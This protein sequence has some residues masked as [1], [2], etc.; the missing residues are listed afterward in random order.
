MFLN[1]HRSRR[2]LIYLH[3]QA[4]TCHNI[5][6]K[7]SGISLTGRLAAYAQVTLWAPSRLTH[8]LPQAMLAAKYLWKLCKFMRSHAWKF[9]PPCLEEDSGELMVLLH[10]EGRQQ[11]VCGNVD[12][13]TLHF[14]IVTLQCRARDLTVIMHFS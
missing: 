1:G 2:P 4:D 9:I 8:A 12:S 7:L 3:C 14:N 5:S 10:V 13:I 6:G 11:D